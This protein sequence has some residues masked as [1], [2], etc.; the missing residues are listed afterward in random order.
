MMSNHPVLMFVCSNMVQ[1]TLGDNGGQKSL[2]LLQ[3]KGCKVRP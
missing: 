1:Q 2:T 3:S